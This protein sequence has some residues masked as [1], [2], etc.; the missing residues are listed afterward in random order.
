MML[1]IIF[2]AFLLSIFFT[3][4]VVLTIEGGLRV[5]FSMRAPRSEAMSFSFVKRW[6]ACISIAGVLFAL[7]MR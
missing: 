3:T 4:E 2:A 1:E 6:R 5:P 7:S